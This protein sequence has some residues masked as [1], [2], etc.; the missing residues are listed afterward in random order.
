MTYNG[1]RLIIN[2]ITIYNSLISKGTYQ[3]VPQK[4]IA[5]SW[6][7]ANLISHEEVLSNHKMDISF[8]LRERTLD[9]Q[10]SIKGIFAT[11]ENVP[12][13]Y[14]DD[15]TCAYKTGTFKMDASKFSH[16][17]TIGGINYNPTTIHLVEN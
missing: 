6:E 4:R 16:R 10:D 9:E 12:V 8:A 11:R 2:G 14:W 3:A 15:E 5:A 17:N 13:T 1:Y 7:D